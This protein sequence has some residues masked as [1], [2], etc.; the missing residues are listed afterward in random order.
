MTEAE[1]QVIWAAIK[2][3]VLGGLAI[4]AIVFVVLFGMRI[5]IDSL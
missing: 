1:A 3:F 5:W 2:A 4:S